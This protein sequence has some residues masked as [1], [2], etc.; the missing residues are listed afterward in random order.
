VLAVC[1][2][3]RHTVAPVVPANLEDHGR[4]CG[5]AVENGGTRSPRDDHVA[6]KD[7]VRDMATVVP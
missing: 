3:D 5:D 2:W 6:A 7:P 1:R 4:R